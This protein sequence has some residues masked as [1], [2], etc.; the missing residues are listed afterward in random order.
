VPEPLHKLLQRRLWFLLSL[1]GLL[2]RSDSP[3]AKKNG[4]ARWTSQLGTYP[5]GHADKKNDV[6]V[7]TQP[8]LDA[9]LSKVSATRLEASSEAS[10]RVFTST[11]VYRCTTCRGRGHLPLLP[12]FWHSAGRL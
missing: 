6:V 10:Q 1:H 11:V 8:E 5:C 12:S 4:L 3:V 9:L 7:L 2:S